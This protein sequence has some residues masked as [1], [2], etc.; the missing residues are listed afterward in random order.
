[1][2]TFS[3][4]NGIINPH[5]STESMAGGS[6]LQSR[7]TFMSNGLLYEDTIPGPD[8]QSLYDA[9]YSSQLVQD[10]NS[11]RN[12]SV[13]QQ[14]G[15]RQSQRNPNVLDDLADIDEEDSV[16]SR[17][18]LRRRCRFICSNHYITCIVL[19]LLPISITATLISVFIIQNK[20]SNSK[21]NL[22]EY[23]IYA[24]IIFSVA[25][26]FPFALFFIIIFLNKI[27]T[28][29]YTAAE[30]SRNRSSLR[31]NRQNPRNVYESVFDHNID[32]EVIS[33][34]RDSRGR[35]TDQ[36]IRQGHGELF[37]TQSGR[38][39]TRQNAIDCPFETVEELTV[40]LPPENSYVRNDE[41]PSYELALMC[42][43]VQTIKSNIKE[44]EKKKDNKDF[45]VKVVKTGHEEPPPPYNEKTM[46]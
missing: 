25:F 29:Y 43:M 42:P 19:L 20:T 5:F 22:H 7:L 17:D 8:D 34:T 33:L 21:D 32:N 36:H 45:V 6:Y 35:G 3:L 37:R 14:E 2:S 38:R 46:K 40:V 10:G 39:L 27:Y 15:S 30:E 23:A 28:N 16:P 24:F 13:L 18:G 9:R 12:Q 26:I 11:N 44:K 41:P 31:T 4:Y 1:M